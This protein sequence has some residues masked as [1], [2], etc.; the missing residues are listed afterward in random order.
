MDASFRRSRARLHFGLAFCFYATAAAF[1]LLPA[2][3]DRTS[4]LPWKWFAVAATVL[5][6]GFGSLI[7]LARR[8]DDSRVTVFAVVGALVTVSLL[9]PRADPAAS[10]H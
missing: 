6:Y 7:T 1:G 4:A 5:L 3:A 9:L 8:P 2:L 10:P